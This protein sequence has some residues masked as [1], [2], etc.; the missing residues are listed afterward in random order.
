MSGSGV[1]PAI[2]LRVDGADAFQRVMDDAGKAAE[3]FAQRA[4]TSGQQLGT[5]STVADDVGTKLGTLSTRAQATSVVLDRMGATQAAGALATFST[6]LDSVGLAASRVGA[7]AAAAET[8]VSAFFARMA[9]GATVIGA[10]VLGLQAAGLGIRA[11]GDAA[12]SAKAASEAYQAGLQA[13]S[14]V[15]GTTEQR[16]LATAQALFLVGRNAAL[17]R[18]ESNVGVLMDRRSEAMRQA[19][20]TSGQLATAEQGLATAQGRLGSVSGLFGS[21]GSFTADVERR[22][23]EVAALRQRLASQQAEYQR[24]GGEIDELGRGIAQGQQIIYATPAG[25]ELPAT[26]GRGSGGGARAS[27]REALGPLDGTDGSLARL[28]AGRMRALEQEDQQRARAAER[29]ARDFERREDQN[30]RVTDRIV[31][32]GAGAFADLFEKNGR[33]WDGLMQTFEQTARQTFARIAAEAVIRPIVAPIVQEL[34]LG[35]L[36]TGNGGFAGIFGGGVSGVGSLPSGTGAAGGVSGG[37]GI[38]SLLNLGGGG[39][40][41]SIGGILGNPIYQSGAGWFQPA[42]SMGQAFNPDTG[43]MMDVFGP[44]APNTGLFDGFAGSSIGSHSLGSTLGGIGTGFAAGSTIG[45]F[46]AGKSKARQQ[47]SQIGAGVGAAVGAIWGPV[48]SMAGGALGGAIG[49]MIGPSKSFSGGDVRVGVGADGRLQVVGSGGKNWDSGAAVS[50]TTQMLDQFNALLAQTGVSVAGGMGVLGTQGF[51]GSKNVFGPTELWNA[52]RSNLTTSNTSLAGAL[53]QPWMQ[54]FED[55]SVIAPFAGQNDNLTRALASGGIRSR[56]D[57]NNASTFITSVYEPLSKVTDASKAF[58]EALAAQNKVYNDAIARARDLGLAETGL[59]AARDKSRA[60]VLE[61]RNR[62]VH[63]AMVSLEIDE[64]RASGTP[65]DLRRAAGLEHSLA[66]SQRLRQMQEFLTGNGYG[67]GTGLFAS[68]TSRL[69][70][71]FAT[72]RK[73]LAQQLAESASG[74]GAS[75]ME[76]LT[77]GGLGGLSSAGRYAAATKA[78]GA[79]RESGNL[80]RI[81]AAG[82]N[83]ATVGRDYLGTSERFG[84]LVSDI[85]RDVRRAGGDPVGLGVFLEGQA[86]G[87]MTLER[88]YSLNNSQLSEL[89]KMRSEIAR[90][91]G[92]IST[93]MQRQSA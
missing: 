75:F 17:A 93:L 54:S 51:G 66:S 25:P 46:V 18:A 85:S 49:G 37:G 35:A 43:M 68:A 87:N 74:S 55:L 72:E 50:S 64:L 45:G 57:F 32:Y 69:T 26:G 90:L 23:R 42:G 58:A 21:R 9:A 63:G 36:G 62:S 48:G 14:T 65:A 11:A 4:A 73:T 34:G 38:G 41:S 15:L 44:A 40:R 84:G 16:A 83:L 53:A 78:Y 88:I 33:G 71:L 86:A 28:E 60:E 3:R 30:R 92:F 24:L 81:T 79:A 91:N 20:L 31:D 47:N 22:E 77:I 5:L 27:T 76:E 10:V 8:G 82:R 2:P 29:E 52:T 80:D 70:A 7:S 56:D 59:I 1:I 6:V 13:L 89:T 61:T 12:V 19:E 39:G 67:E